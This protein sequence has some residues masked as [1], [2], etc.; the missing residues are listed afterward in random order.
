MSA[1]LLKYS[2]ATV[3]FYP[4]RFAL[5]FK[6]SNFVHKN[7]HSMCTIYRLK[8]RLNHEDFTH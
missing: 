7:K 5:S 1:S 8:E 6:T 4:K 3:T 2:G